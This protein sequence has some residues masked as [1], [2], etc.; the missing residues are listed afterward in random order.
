MILFFKE[1]PIINFVSQLDLWFSGKLLKSTKI[2]LM[3]AALWLQITT[4]LAGI[5]LPTHQTPF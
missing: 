2:A 1:N 4:I 5:N 3:V